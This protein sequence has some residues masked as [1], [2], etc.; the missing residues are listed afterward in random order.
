[1]SNNKFSYQVNGQ[2][3]NLPIDS[4]HIALKFYEPSPRSA[5]YKFVT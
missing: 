1:M 3:I 4:G 2:E 5:R